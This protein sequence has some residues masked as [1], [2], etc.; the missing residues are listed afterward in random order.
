MDH[1]EVQQDD[2]KEDAIMQAREDAEAW[3]H[4]KQ[5]LED[6]RHAEE[7]ATRALDWLDTAPPITQI[8]REE[9]AALRFLTGI[10]RESK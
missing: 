7:L 6:C 5:Y 8:S 10:P 2:E 4:E 9:I 1:D 3:Q